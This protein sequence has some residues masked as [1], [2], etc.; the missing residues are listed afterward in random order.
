MGKMKQYKKYKPSGI[1]WIG[2]IP[3][4]W[5]VKKLKYVT[6]DVITGKTPPSSNLDYYNGSIDWFS[7][8]DFNNKL[9]LSDSKRKITNQ[10]IEEAGIK[11]Y[12]PYSV[13]LIGI[14]ATLG[15]I[16]ITIS[17]A[18]SNQQIN[19]IIFNEN[20]INPFFGL[21][22]LMSFKNEII[23][24]ANV[25]TLAIFNQSQTKEL[26]LFVPSSEEQTAIA[27]YLDKKTS[28]IDKLISQKENLLKLYEEEKTAIINQAVTKGIDPDVK[29]KDSGLDWLGDIPK[30]WK[31][32]RVA[33]LGEFSK[34][35]GIP[36]SELKDSGCPAILYGDIYTK[37]NLKADFIYNHISEETAKSAIKIQFG[38]ILFTGSGE[39]IEDIGKCITY[40][41]NEN[42]Y[43]GGDVI[44]LKQEKCNSLFLS[45]SL[46][47]NTSIFQKARMAKGEII[48]HIYASN[49]RE[50]ILLEPLLKE[51]TQ[52][53]QYIETETVRINAKS[54]KTKKLIE[55]LKEY[56]TAL[57]SEVVTGKVKV[58]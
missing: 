10:A 14:G 11:L 41:G 58:A 50:I 55:L 42:V 8:G 17:Q 56:K 7:P 28:E 30:H 40:V 36:R 47:S 43:V 16:G 2:E 4:H 54:E 35:K 44:I 32:K 21:Y 23:R 9:V 6:K 53:V 39:T 49:L 51:Q 26:E 45:Y 48:V 31:A 5:D 27:N 57:I 12:P 33:T 52:I 1:E 29:L 37:Y 34:G 13:L 15:K 25:A 46:S 19:A 18:T 38:D 24:L 20:K 3:E 22:F